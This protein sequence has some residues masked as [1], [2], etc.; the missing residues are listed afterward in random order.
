MNLDVSTASIVLALVKIT[1]LLLVAI[2]VSPLVK[3]AAHRAVVW[4]ITLFALP[5]LAGSALFPGVLKIIPSKDHDR[6]VGVAA[7]GEYTI[8]EEHRDKP[9]EASAPSATR[10]AD[11]SEAVAI[12]SPLIEQE[13]GLALRSVQGPLPI[14]LLVYGS[15]VFLALLSTGISFL[16]I[17][18]L[19]WRPASGRPQGVMRELDRRIDLCFTDS[20][21]APF[22]CGVFRPRILLPMEATA[23][24]DRR[25]K[26]VLA[27][28]LAHLRRRDPLVRLLATALRAAFWFHPLVW[29]AHQRLILAQEEACDLEAIR[30]GI[31]PADYAEDLLCL[32]GLAHHGPMETLAMARRSQLG[33]RVERVLSPSTTNGNSIFWKAIPAVSLVTILTV[34]GFAER[35]TDD[36]GGEIARGEA[37]N[38]R[39]TTATGKATES[40]SVFTWSAADQYGLRLGMAGI[41]EGETIGLE[42]QIRFQLALRNEG[43]R[44][45][46]FTYTPYHPRTLKLKLNGRDLLRNGIKEIQRPSRYQIRPGELVEFADFHLQFREK[47]KRANPFGFTIRDPGKFSMSAGVTLSGIEVIN[48]QGRVLER[49]ADEWQGE[50]RTMRFAVVPVGQV[51]LARPGMERYLVDP[52]DYFGDT[53]RLR[54][55][56][57]G[58]ADVALRGAS[59]WKFEEARD[60]LAAW[61]RGGSRIWCVDSDR[62]V[63]RISVFNW[64]EL[65]GWKRYDLD[66]DLEGMPQAVRAALK[67]PKPSRR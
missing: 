16:R 57:A 30:S 11:S 44:S 24:T 39:P 10:S 27:H 42:T 20:S 7:E 21:S 66:G 2:A 28:E 26:S 4:V 32:A 41:R 14:T 15:G 37:G 31:A 12:N 6:A 5:L 17:F 33:K 65:G 1:A 18:L 3:S 23:W 9:E 47:G 35:P 13:Q 56:R 49:L 53:Q 55:T 67:L 38:E 36:P 64:K 8:G 45:L 61:E 58:I 22:T 29:L 25:L 50:S 46:Q 52:K 51:M 19:P 48:H 59:Y 54:F 34:T 43:K 60:F 40:G 62:S 63:L